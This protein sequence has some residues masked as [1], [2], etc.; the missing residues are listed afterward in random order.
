MDIN[1]TVLFEMQRAAPSQAWLARQTLKLRTGIAELNRRVGDRCVEPSELLTLGDIAV[2]TTLTMFDFLVDQKIVP[3]EPG[4]VWR[5]QYPALSEYV[6]LLELRPSF[7]ATRPVM[8]DV[9]V[10]AVVG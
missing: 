10:K 8:Q 6:D 5:G 2:G 3:E 7:A 9:D 1:T 4:F